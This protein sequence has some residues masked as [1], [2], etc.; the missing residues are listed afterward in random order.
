MKSQEEKI[1]LTVRIPKSLM[2]E[3]RQHTVDYE[4]N[5]TEITTNALLDYLKRN[6]NKK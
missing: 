1:K 6:P 2:K 3:L 5:L 4:I